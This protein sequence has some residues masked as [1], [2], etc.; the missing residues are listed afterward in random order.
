MI[1]LVQGVALGVIGKAADDGKHLCVGTGRMTVC[2][3]Y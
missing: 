2:Q 1:V 3:H